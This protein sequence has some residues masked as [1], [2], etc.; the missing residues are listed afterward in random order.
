MAI[1]HTL[2]MLTRLA[3]SHAM[4]AGASLHALRR[5]PAAAFEPVE[6]G[7]DALQD[8]LVASLLAMAMLM[9]R[10]TCH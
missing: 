1:E 5:A 9:R 3:Q 6:D 10:P 8:H 2:Q 4:L 7:N